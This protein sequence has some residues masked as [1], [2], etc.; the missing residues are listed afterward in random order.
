M[1][2]LTFLEGIGHADHCQISVTHRPK[3]LR[4]VWHHILPQVCGGKTEAPNLVSLCDSCHY[5]IHIIM[6]NLANHGI[7]GVH[8]WNTQ[9]IAYAQRGYL[10]AQAAGVANL[11]PKEA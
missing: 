10:E 4:Y 6:W 5:T 1:T 7:P 11:I 3:T 8:R 2:A 9:Q